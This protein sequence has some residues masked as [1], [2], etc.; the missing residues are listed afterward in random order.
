M[1]QAE[2]PLLAFIQS[3][4]GDEARQLQGGVSSEVLEAMGQLVTSL[5]RDMNVAPDALT[6]APVAKMREV[7]VPPR[8]PHPPHSQPRPPL[9]PLT[10]RPARRQVLIL[11]L[12]QGYKLRELEV[13]AELKGTFWDQ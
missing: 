6:E 13:R 9:A 8:P 5:L 7:A 1:P 11:Q 2:Q 3:L 4:P 12:V 10:D